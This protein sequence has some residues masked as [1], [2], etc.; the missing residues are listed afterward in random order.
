MKR[1][2]IWLALALALSPCIASAKDVCIQLNDNGD[3]IVLKGGVRKGSKGVSGHY[4]Q[5]VTIVGGVPIYNVMPM[6][7]SAILGSNGNFVMGL[8]HYVLGFSQSSN[9]FSGATVFHHVSCTLGADGKLSIPDTCSDVTNS[10]PGTA[11]QLSRPGIVAD[12]GVAA[13]VQ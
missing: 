13:L 10:H 2:A 4:A 5:F 8:T 11:P 6:T 9:T 12:C 3:V 7:G 1:H